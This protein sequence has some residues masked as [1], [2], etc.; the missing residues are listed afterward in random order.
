M[1]GCVLFRLMR[2]KGLELFG[3]EPEVAERI[4][5]LYDDILAD[6]ISHVGLIEA[7]LGGSR[8]A[9]MHRLYRALA[10]RMVRS[11]SPE[12]RALLGSERVAGALRAP[13]DQGQ[14]AAGFPET[15]YAF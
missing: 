3:G 1:T 13:F 14:L 4:R 11:L 2:D 9:R 10:P 15:A 8:S 7:R 5:V 12:C 6:E